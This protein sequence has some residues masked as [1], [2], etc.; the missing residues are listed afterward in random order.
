MACLRLEIMATGVLVS[1]FMIQTL[2][3]HFKLPDLD[4]TRTPLI[5]WGAGIRGPI[6][7][8]SSTHQMPDVYSAPWDLS[9][10][11]RRD[12]EQADVAA[13]MSALIGIHWPINSVGVLPDVDPQKDGYLSMRGGEREIAEAVVV[14]AKVNL[15]RRYWLPSLTSNQVILEHYRVKHGNGIIMVLLL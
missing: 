13:L 15:S 4:N 6:L 3:I 10:I 9:H 7:N 11:V 8:P 12:V 1:H 5:A 2:F 14:N